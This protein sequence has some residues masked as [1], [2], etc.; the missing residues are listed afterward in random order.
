MLVLHFSNLLPSHALSQRLCFG[1]L[2][3]LI[4]LPVLTSV[5]GVII[6]IR[7]SEGLYWYIKLFCLS[8]DPSLVVKLMPICVP[9]PLPDPSLELELM[10]ICFPYPLPDPSLG[11]ERQYVFLILYLIHLW[12]L[13]SCQY[14]F[15]IPP[16]P[17]LGV[18]LMSIYPSETSPRPDQRNQKGYMW[19]HILQLFCFF[20][21]EVKHK[22]SV[23]CW[24]PKSEKLYTSKGNW[25]ARSRST[26]HDTDSFYK[27][28]YLSPFWTLS[29]CP[30]S[31]PPSPPPASQ[32]R[33][34]GSLK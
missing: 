10:S 27:R 9:Y 26:S 4:Q 25:L 30:L 13:N 28:F 17:S 12:E 21:T 3:D 18:E 14:V 2:P 32:Y 19:K 5:R 31:W 16:D 20:D 8:T 22:Y 23:I 15:L 34:K 1:K 29:P 24:A 33:L 7:T 6:Y 11:V